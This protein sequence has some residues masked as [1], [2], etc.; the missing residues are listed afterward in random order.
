MGLFSHIRTA[1]PNLFFTRILYG[2]VASLAIF[3]GTWDFLDRTGDRIRSKFQYKFGEETYDFIIV[4]GGTAG[5]VLATRLAE[6][7]DWKILVLEAGGEPHPFQAIPAFTYF[8]LNHKQIDFGYKTVPQ[9]KACAALVGQ[10]S[11][12][13]AGRGL[14]GSMNLNFM[15]YL[16]GTPQDYNNWA[17]FTGDPQWAYAGVLPYFKKIEDYRGSYAGQDAHGKGGKLRIEQPD[18]TGL[19]AEFVRAGMEL[20]YSQAD[21][22]GFVHEGFDALNYPIKRGQRRTTFKAYLRRAR[23]KKNLTVYKFSTVNKILIRGPQKQA[24]GVEYER[25]GKMR[26]ATATKEII[27]TAGAV[28]SPKILM[29]SGIGP[30]EQLED[31]GVFVLQI[32]AFEF[33]I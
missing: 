18:Y 2:V 4:G 19:A 1:F 29:L 16:R 26:T 27:L 3:V 9:E 7:R 13:H 22:N 28:Q 30:K 8:M 23:R 32:F 25:H 20:G 14:G 33:L 17:N 24:Y 12:W 21:L 10:Q 6:N 31:L 5:S 15:T 11:L